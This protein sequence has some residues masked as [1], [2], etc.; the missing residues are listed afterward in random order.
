MNT[1]RSTSTPATTPTL[2]DVATTS[3]AKVRQGV[4]KILRHTEDPKTLE[5]VEK[6]AH[7][8]LV[9]LQGEGGV[10]PTTQVQVSEK[11]VQ[12]VG[13]HPQL[14]TGDEVIF[15]SKK[16][17]QTRGKFLRYT[18]KFAAIETLAPRGRNHKWETGTRFYWNLDEVTPIVAEVKAPKA[19]RAP[20]T[21]KAQKTAT[22]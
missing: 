9:T 14:T 6:A 2:P 15:G 3:P 10:A 5:A 22:G 1:N 7:L 8:R 16:G 20:R 21:A 4:L 13:N 11:A 18:G 17:E 19:A 12:K